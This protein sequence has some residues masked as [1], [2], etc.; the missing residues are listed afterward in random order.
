M[1][2]LDEHKQ[3]LDRMLDQASKGRLVVLAGAGVSMPP[4]S[5]RPSWPALVEHMATHAAKFSEARAKAML[6]Q[7]QTDLLAAI[8]LYE[9]GNAIPKRDREQFLREEFQTE[10][11]QVPELCTRDLRRA[12]RT[13]NS[14]ATCF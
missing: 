1:A 5:R 6:E 14:F 7:K 2:I 12:S 3:I 4:P 8:D 9:I 10:P 11:H 13:S